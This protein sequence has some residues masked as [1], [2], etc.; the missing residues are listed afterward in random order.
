[1]TAHEPTEKPGL[2]D[3]IM[4]RVKPGADV[5][6]KLE[7]LQSEHDQTIV[8]LAD[9]VAKVTEAEA[10]SAALEAEKTTLVASHAQ[11]IAALNEAHAKALEDAKIQGAQEFAAKGLVGNAPRPLPHVETPDEE[12]HTTH[13]AKWNALRASG[14][15]AAAGEYYDKH[16]TDI[17]RGK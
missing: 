9:A 12:A 15:Y 17:L 11:E 14:D 8:A 1:M 3:R 16:E 6:A 4:S 5:V 10:K 7:A 2:L 13:T